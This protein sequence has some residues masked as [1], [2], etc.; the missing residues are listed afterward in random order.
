MTIEPVRFRPSFGRILSVVVVLIMVSA[1]SGYLLTGNIEGFFR[2]SWWYAV[3][4]GLVV[5]MYWSPSVD[6]HKNGVRIRNPLR[7][8]E[9]PWAAI[10][11]IDTRFALTLFTPGRRIEAW[12]APASGRF[13]VFR[14]G[15]DDLRVSESARVA[16][17]VRPGDTL[18][19]ES[20]QA[21][22]YIRCHWERMRDTESL[23]HGDGH[24]TYRWHGA[25]S[26]IL[27]G[28]VAGATIAT[29]L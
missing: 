1:A 19:S 14:V 29:M 11:R 20:G 27:A 21:A 12:A 26:A 22:E 24:V 2:Y 17:S 6:V 9:V 16:G 10:E 15:P 3:V 13:T 4:A 8:W 23:D 28:L 18:A 25:T 7:T 5:A